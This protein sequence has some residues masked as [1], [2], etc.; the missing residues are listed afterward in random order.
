M[1]KRTL[2][3]SMSLLLA[4]CGASPAAPTDIASVDLEKLSP[5]ER[6]NYLQE[7]ATFFEQ[8]N[9]IGTPS[10]VDCTLSEG[11]KTTCFSI[12]VKPTPGGYTPGP[13]CPRNISDDKEKSGIWLDEG[14]I[15]DAD[16]KFLQNLSDFYQDDEWQI[17]DSATGKINVTDTKEK[18]AAAARPDVDEKYQN[19]CVECQLDYM[20]AESS[21]T[22]VIPVRPLASKSSSRAQGGAG[23]A[24]NGIRLDGPA[25]VDAILGAHTLAPFDDCGGHVNLHVG[26]H[27]HAVTDCL[28]DKSSKATDKS[29]APVIGLAMDGYKILTHKLSNGE[30][31]TKLDSCQGHS[32]AEYGYHYH[33]GAAG[34]NQILGCLTGQQGC[35]F[36]G[37]GDSCDATVRQGPP[38]GGGP[39]PGGGRRPPNPGGE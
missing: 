7:A 4:S 25:P 32:T 8:A 21:M 2:L 39:P 10:L 24:I 28:V 23:V 19:H 29:D 16:G 14:K 11:T 5:A 22:Y 20:P 15:Y 26:Y 6:D 36:E 38:G 30:M 37:S 33:A 35:S 18:C 34:S 17:F 1:I 27:Y 3:L 9:I 12:I 31:P 13:W